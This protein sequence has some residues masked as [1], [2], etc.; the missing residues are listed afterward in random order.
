MTGGDR[1]VP[2]RSDPPPGQIPTWWLRLLLLG[3]LL[4]A[5]GTTLWTEYHGQGGDILSS[6]PVLLLHV[7]GGACLVLWSWAAM[8]NIEALV[9]ATRY[10]KPARGWLAATLWLSAVAAPFGV[11]AVHDRVRDRLGEPNDST[12]VLILLAAVFVAFIMVWLPFGYCGR[13]GARLGAPRSIMVGWFFAPLIAAVGSLG[14][15]ALGLRDQLV[16][17]GLTAY[18]RFVGVG[19]VYGLPMFVF[20]L[21][22]WRAI[23][24][25]DEVLDLRW[26]Q[27]K[28]E[29]EQTLKDFSDQ[30]A[31][32]PEDSPPV[33]RLYRRSIG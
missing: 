20:A 14:I 4:G 28:N 12:P 22:T 11:L 26:R 31:P 17:D 25:I 13:K 29:W 3:L 9:P 16:E 23:T 7:G 2:L 24:V 18:E 19:V 5:L 33:Q 15:Y 1:F 10:Q 6:L 32:G 30:P 8:N 27:W 21:S